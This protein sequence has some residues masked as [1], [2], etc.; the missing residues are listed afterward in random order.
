MLRFH[1]VPVDACSFD[2]VSSAG[3]PSA[4]TDT[5]AQHSNGT[6][7]PVSRPQNFQRKAVP[8]D[9]AVALAGLGGDQQPTVLLDSLGL[10]LDSTSEVWS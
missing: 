8:R 7:E 6:S 10:L 5:P 9:Q 2:G 3:S 4:T 1:A